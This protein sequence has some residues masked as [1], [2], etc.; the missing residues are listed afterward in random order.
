MQEE[1]LIFA[2]DIGTR[3][4]VGILLQKNDEKFEIVDV[5]SIEHPSRAML[6]GQ[7]HDVK[8]VA[9]SIVRVKETLEKKHGTLTEVSIAA[10]GRA[11]KTARGRAELTLETNKRVS[12]QAI[13]QLELTA[14]QTAQRSILEN[15]TEAE[16]SLHYFC[17][18]YSVLHYAIDGQSIGNLLDQKGDTASVEVVATFLPRVVVDSLMIAL[19][20]ADLTMRTLTLEPIAAINALVPSTMRKLNIALVDIGAGTSDIAITKDNTVIAYG[21][22]PVAGDEMTERIGEHYLLDFNEAERLKRALVPNEQVTL[23]DILGFEYTYTYDEVTEVL[24]PTVQQLATR[25]AQ[26]IVALNEQEPQA[27]MLIGGG[28]LTPELAPLLAEALALPTNRVAVRDP[29]AIQSL[30]QVST[31]FASPLYVTPLGIAIQASEHTVNYLSVT[32]N[33]EEVTLYDMRSVTVSDSILALGLPIH[34]LYGK[35]GLALFVKINGQTVRLP[36]SL[37]GAPTITVNGLPASMDTAIQHNDDILIETGQDGESPQIT[38]AD[39]FES[40]TALRFTFNE[41]VYTV[42][43]ICTVQGVV[44]GREYIVQ[45]GDEIVFKIPDSIA[46]AFTAL[47]ITLESSVREQPITILLNG[48]PISQTTSDGYWQMNGIPETSTTKIQNDAHITRVPRP[49]GT[50]GTL[51]ADEG[52]VLE[53]TF[54]AY[55]NGQQIVIG[56]ECATVV[57]DGQTLRSDTPLRDGMD[58][59]VQP[60]PSDTLVLQDLFAHVD[61]DLRSSLHQGY[62]LTMNGAPA[63]FTTPLTDGC[64]VE[65]TFH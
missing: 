2:L 5:A 8:S 40:E 9:T 15:T 28:S 47:N 55:F 29:R 4:I 36:G 33:G 3:S 52:I 51:L 25:I 23:T 20:R 35:P 61:L 41:T 7:I 34:R 17:V 56:Q 24:R 16:D 10:A 26:E 63:T 45:D 38:I 44:V 30:E 58:I 19:K 32:V 50:V 43:A 42:Q 18:G 65:L 54:T 60:K 13:T 21:M 14:V 53:N 46:Q 48:K 31:Q 39:L 49:V 22:V 12:A 37:G 59:R 1:S 11:L 27:V 6:D 57:S 62:T 64:K